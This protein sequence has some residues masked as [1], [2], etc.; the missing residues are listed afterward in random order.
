MNFKGIAELRTQN[1]NSLII[2]SVEEINP[3]PEKVS[4]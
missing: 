2:L 1:L 3:D 4:L